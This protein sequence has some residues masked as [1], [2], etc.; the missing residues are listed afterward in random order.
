MG[1]IAKDAVL[2][3]EAARG[4][5][6]G[7]GAQIDE[8]R[9]RVLLFA[10]EAVG[11]GSDAVAGH[12]RAKRVKVLAEGDFSLP[13]RH[14]ADGAEG[15]GQ[16]VLPGGWISEGTR[17]A[18]LLPNQTE[19]AQITGGCAALARGEYLGQRAGHVLDVIG[20]HA[21]KNLGHAVAVPVV[22]VLRRGDAAAD[23]GEAV[24]RV[25]DVVEL[26]VGE[27]VAVGV[28]GE[29]LAVKL[30]EAV[31][32]VVG[33][34]GDRLAVARFQ[35]TIT[36]GIVAISVTLSRTVGC[37]SEAIERVVFVLDGG[38]A[39]LRQAAQGLVRGGLVAGQTRGCERVEIAA[40]QIDRFRQIHARARG[41]RPAEADQRQGDGCAGEGANEAAALA[42]AISQWGQQPQRP[43]EQQARVA[44]DGGGNLE[45]VALLLRRGGH[46]AA[47]GGEPGGDAGRRRRQ[48]GQGHVAHA[49]AFAGTAACGD[50]V[51]VLCEQQPIEAQA[52]FARPEGDGV[53]TRSGNVQGGGKAG[54]GLVGP[55][56]LLPGEAGEAEGG[57]AI[58][59]DVEGVAAG[60]YR[61]PRAPHYIIAWRA[62]VHLVLQ[63]R[64]A[65]QII[66]R[67]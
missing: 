65:R 46:M 39:G 53:E 6:V 55:T 30:D 61:R 35:E 15:V 51:C 27:Q 19:A 59:T 36:A 34:A 24:G 48:L 3:Q 4:R 58:D 20:A 37:G 44:Q 57:R 2:L 5:V 22:D 64:A 14:L 23:L 33:V 62:E 67:I 63:L 54:G 7:A 21:V 66:R 31:G 52:V 16:G 17:S 26:A 32:D 29:R 47:V 45:P 9:E 43:E 41:Q 56:P 42:A 28:V 50:V 11:A 12:H 40:R 13:V 10:G 49:R 18:V 25:V 60:I 38:S 1:R 8:A